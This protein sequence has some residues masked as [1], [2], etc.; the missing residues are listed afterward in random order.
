[1]SFGKYHNIDFKILFEIEAKSPERITNPF[2][3]T[4]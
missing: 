2:K 3:T 4:A 1:M